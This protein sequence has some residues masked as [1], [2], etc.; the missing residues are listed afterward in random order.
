MQFGLLSHGRALLL[1][2]MEQNFVTV[3]RSLSTTGIGSLP[4][5]RYMYNTTGTAVA[6]PLAHCGLSHLLLV[7][8]CLKPIQVQ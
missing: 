5:V 8:Q 6:S 7:F 3:G 4:Q 1:D 2:V